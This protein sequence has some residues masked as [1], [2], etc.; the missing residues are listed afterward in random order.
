[1]NS[2]NKTNYTTKLVV[3][4]ILALALALGLL[5]MQK[6]KNRDKLKVEEQRR[7]MSRYMD[8]ALNR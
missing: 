2:I 6:I 8:D 7:H 4:A 5:V 1:M 3:P